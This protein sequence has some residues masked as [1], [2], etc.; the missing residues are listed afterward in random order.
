MPVLKQISPVVVPMAPAAFR[1]HQAVQ[2][3]SAL[4]AYHGGF[5]RRRRDLGV[6][7]LALR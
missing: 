7:D 4:A 2:P 5:E 3:Q 6:A 1:V